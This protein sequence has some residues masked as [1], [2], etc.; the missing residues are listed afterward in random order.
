M[1]PGFPGGPPTPPLD[2]AGMRPVAFYVQTDPE[3]NIVFSSPQQQLNSDQVQDLV[4]TVRRQPTLNGRIDFSNTLYFFLATPRTDQPGTLFIFQDFER[5]YSVFRTTM[6]SLAWIGL[7]CFIASLGGSLFLARW[8]MR[9]IQQA[10]DRQK[11]F[12][13]DASHELRTPLAVIQASLD[14]IRSNADEQVSEQK[15]WLDNMGESV[16]SMANLVDSLL[17]LARID[18]SQHP[19]AKK[20][21]ALDKAIANEVELF[22]PLADAKGIHLFTALDSR[23]QLFGDEARIKQVLG[24][25]LD[26]AIR[27][28]PA[29]G[30]IEVLLQQNQRNVQLTVTDSG[31]GIPKEHLSRIFERFYQVDPARNKEGSGLGL[32]IAK[33]I[34]ESHQGTI[35]ALS[36]PNSG[37]TF[38]IR[39]PLSKSS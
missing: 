27:H 9:P 26:N 37:T 12:L 23:I 6:K 11:D 14:V 1:L 30:T 19:I 28:T 15:Q 34:I 35:Q 22:K 3:G 8:A 7:I 13:A 24:I 4:A 16:A 20:T 5:E 10:W 2:D 17:F 38:Q 18:S 36:K 31:D 29:E 25:I 39:L 32:S 33:C 21:F